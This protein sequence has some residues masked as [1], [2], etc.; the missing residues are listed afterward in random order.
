M[1]LNLAG[2]QVTQEQVVQRIFGGDINS[3]GTVPQIMGALS[4][5]A[6]TGTGKS[7]QL[8]PSM[9]TNDAEMID[10]LSH[11]WPIIAALSNGDGTGHAEVVTAVKFAQGFGNTISLTSV[12]L[13]D[14]WPYNAS[15]VEMP[16]EQFA[17][18]RS[19]GIRYRVVYPQG[20]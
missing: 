15:R 8:Y 12:V 4:G 3:G 7:V 16:Y 6:F 17:R 5:W 1:V 10:D 11:G 13:R 14:P 18:R 2:V 20:Y 9:L 19:A